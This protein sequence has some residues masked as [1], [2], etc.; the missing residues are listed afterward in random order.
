MVVPGR[1][2]AARVK[3]T[4]KQTPALPPPATGTRETDLYP[5]V[6]DFLVGQGF[7]VRAEVR[8]CDVTAVKG[9]RVVVVEM[10]LGLTLDL[11]LQGVRRQK[12]ADLVYLAVP[13]PT[14]TRHH[15]RLR[16]NLPIL[17]QLEIGLLL[18]DFRAHPPGLEVALQPLPFQRRRTPKERRA[19]LQEVALRSGDD[20]AGGSRGRPLVTA[21]RE[22]ALLIAAVLARL[23]ATMPKALR[24]L[25][26]GEK[27]RA[28]LYDNVYGWF[29]RLGPASY[30]IAKKGELALE[31]YADVVA[32][33]T[34]R[35]P[36]PTAAS[37]PGKSPVRLASVKKP[38]PSASD[39]ADTYVSA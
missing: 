17:R 2:D 15:A 32:R 5:P 35:L 39:E 25:G 26:T 7:T 3:A 18:V 10:K 13:R 21:Y 27:T 31:T 29:E 14:T 19:I 34:A 24:A 12:V 11:V 4:R 28:I 8:G 6:R 20:N 1:G 30:R 37:E 23:G 36:A 38:R 9:E 33:V 22:N 16:E